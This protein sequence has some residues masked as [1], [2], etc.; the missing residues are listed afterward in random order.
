MLDTTLNGP[1]PTGLIL[2]WSGLVF[3][4]A[5]G[6]AIQLTLDTGN[7]L[8]TA[9]YGRVKCS[10]TVR[11]PSTV[12]PL[13]ASGQVGLQVHAEPTLRRKL[14]ATASASIGVPSVNLIP[15]RMVILTVLPSSSS[16]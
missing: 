9:A 14:V 1:A 13:S 16:S 8:I 5:V 4:S 11:G 10:V 3:C 2:N 12:M 15:S 6:E 7:A